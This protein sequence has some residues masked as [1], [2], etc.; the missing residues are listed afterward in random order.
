MPYKDAEKRR[1]YQRD[2]KRRQRA[3]AGL[4]NPGRPGMR[5]AY[6]CYKLPSLRFPGIIFK[7]GL[8]VTDRPEEQARIEEDPMYGSE[9][10]SWVLEP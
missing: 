5:R 4:T 7:S 3:Q 6:V 10:F 8:F 2:Y 1:I 9:I